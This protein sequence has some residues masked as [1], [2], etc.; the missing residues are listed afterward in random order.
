M[1]KENKMY[2]ILIGFKS[3]REIQMD[4]EVFTVSINKLSGDITKINWE[5][6]KDGKPMYIDLSQ[7]EYIYSEAMEEE[8][9]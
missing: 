5:G 4:C 2:R 8:K 7:V 1:E 9:E 3:G 6:C